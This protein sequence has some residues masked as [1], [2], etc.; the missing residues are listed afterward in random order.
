MSA[1]RH[2][3]TRAP[4]PVSIDAGATPEEAASVAAVLR[5]YEGAGLGVR[6]VTAARIRE[7]IR[8]EFVDDAVATPEGPDA[9]NTVSDC[10]LGTDTVASGA[11]RVEAELVRARVRVARRSGPDWRGTPHPL[12]P[13][14]RGGLLLHEIGHALGFSGHARRGDTVMVREIDEVRRV[15][16]GLIRSRP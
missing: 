15:L 9:G 7:G 14:E 4:I 1:L 3:V 8:V 6:F 13:A 11:S 2:T 16:H 10:R 5:A 12:S